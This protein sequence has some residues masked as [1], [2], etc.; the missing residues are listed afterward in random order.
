[1]YFIDLNEKIKTFYCSDCGQTCMT[2]WGFIRRD[3]TAHAVYYAG[4]MTGH[5]QPSVRLT[6]SLGAWGSTNE[7]GQDARL[8]TWL[9]IESRPT[10]DSYEMMVREP[11]ESR[12][13]NKTILGKPMPRAE[14]IASPSLQEFF[15]VADFVAFNDPAVKSYLCGEQVSSLGRKG[16]TSE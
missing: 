11:Q 2:V 10:A 9:F 4:L 13:F 3:G 16:L 6:I 5:L 7:E 1:V 8:R 14:A 12:Y 15:A